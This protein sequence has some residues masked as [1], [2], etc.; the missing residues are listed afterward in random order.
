[1]EN[2]QVPTQQ[3]GVVLN[4]RELYEQY[5]EATIQLKLAQSKVMML[6]QQIQ[7]LLNNPQAKWRFFN[8]NLPIERLV[9]TS[10]S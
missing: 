2:V 10:R 1:M 4:A 7:Q 3:Q 5:G 9:E 8:L 6:E